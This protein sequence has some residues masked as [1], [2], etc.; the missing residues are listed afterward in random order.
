MAGNAQHEDV[1]ARAED[2]VLAAGEHHGTDLGVLEA[3]ATD[4]VVQFDVDAQVV[5]I[6]LEFVAGAQ[7]GVFVEVG[8]QGG[9]RAFELELPVVILR[10][11]GLVVDGG[12]S[13]QGRLLG[14][15]HKNA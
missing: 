8:H 5:T 12:G 2:L 7:A 14:F 10:G 11:M 1:G 13:G 9:H 6:E 4:G 15:R 3:D